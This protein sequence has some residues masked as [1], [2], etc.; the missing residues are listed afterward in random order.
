MAL[1]I[2]VLAKG[3]SGVT[4]TTLQ[5]YVDALN[6]NCIPR[7]PE[8]QLFIIYVVYNNLFAQKGTVGASG[9]LAPLAHLALGLLGEGKMWSGKHKAYP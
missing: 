6:N 8:V 1:R 7:V 2:N 3:Y 9:D 5:Q 4:P